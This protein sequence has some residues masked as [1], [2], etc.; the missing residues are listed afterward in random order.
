M[1]TNLNAV[2]TEPDY[3]VSMP[4]PT[5]VVTHQNFIS[6]FQTVHNFI[7]WVKNMCSTISDNLSSTDSNVSTNTDNISTANTN[8]SSN[9]TAISNAAG[10]LGGSITSG[11]P[12]DFVIGSPTVIAAGDNRKLATEKINNQCA[13]NLES[14]NSINSANSTRDSNVTS[15]SNKI[16]T[17][18][19]DGVSGLAISDSYLL[20]D[21]YNAEQLLNQVDNILYA[22]RRNLNFNTIRAYENL[23]CTIFDTLINSDEI[24]TGASLPTDGY[25]NSLQEFSDENAWY[26]TF[27]SITVP[28][29]TN[30]VFVAFNK[31]GTVTC[32][33]NGTSVTNETL[34]TISDTASLVVKFDGGAGSKL[35]SYGL[36]YSTV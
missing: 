26:V 25:K 30:R 32:T 34:T 19:T 29:G 4:D 3:P 7:L 23:N 9:T 17:S 10:K 22:H 21:K 16:S 2:A 20:T 36:Y 28:A 8:I 14:I 12:E 1:A 11:S 27:N 24:N 18:A 5:T 13:A 35:F 33:V 6:L 31:E 15:I